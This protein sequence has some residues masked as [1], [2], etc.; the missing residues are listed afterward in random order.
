MV[1]ADLL[2]EFFVLNRTVSLLDP[3]D[4]R[5]SKHWQSRIKIQLL[6]RALL[7]TEGVDEPRMVRHLHTVLEW[8]VDP[9][10]QWLSDACAG[11]RDKVDENFGVILSHPI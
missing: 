9:H 8:T 2:N 4:A 5:V 3:P 1:S 11:T 6:P 7:F 10:V